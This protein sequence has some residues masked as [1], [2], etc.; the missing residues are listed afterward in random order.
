M[1]SSR[2]QLCRF[3]TEVVIG[4]LPALGLQGCMRDSPALPLGSQGTPSSFSSSSS[5][6]GDLDFQSP[7]RSQGHRPGKGEM[8]SLRLGVGPGEGRRGASLPTAMCLTRPVSKPGFRAWRG[9]REQTQD[10]FWV[11][12]VCFSDLAQKRQDNI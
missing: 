1:V 9:R 12:G 4:P 7:E 6:D 5:S 10:L 11:V 2:C 3:P 8:A